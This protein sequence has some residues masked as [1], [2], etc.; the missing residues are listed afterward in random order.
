ML[1]FITIFILSGI[2]IAI[3]L[4]KRVSKARLLS[5]EELELVINSKD[6]N[7]FKEV[8]NY[9]FIPVFNFWDTVIVPQIYHKSEKTAHRVRIYTLKIERM[10]HK[11]ANYIRGRRE[12]KINGSASVYLKDLNNKVKK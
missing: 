6:N 2:N 11:F 9:L 10:L 4:S 8:S 5:E 12:L 7:F 1:F 3:L